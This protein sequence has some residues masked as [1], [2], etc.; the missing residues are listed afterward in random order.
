[1]FL[2]A[3]AISC[4]E[5]DLGLC[6]RVTGRG[7]GRMRIRVLHVK[8]ERFGEGVEREMFTVGCK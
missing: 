2:F 6:E 7:R 4:I 8:K 3:S 1:M 5:V